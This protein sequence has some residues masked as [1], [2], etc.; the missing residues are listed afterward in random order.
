MQS[1][2]KNWKI[3]YG[4]LCDRKMNAEIKGKVYRTVATPAL[5]YGAETWTLKK[6]QEKKLGVA[7]MRMLRWMCRATKLDKIRNERIR[8]TTKVGKITTKVQ[9]MRLKW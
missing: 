7:E 4:V 5:M 8:G 9:E 1:G 2:W 6:A 3:V